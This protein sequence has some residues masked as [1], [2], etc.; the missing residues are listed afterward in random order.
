MAPM[1]TLHCKADTCPATAG[2]VA[3]LRLNHHFRPVAQFYCCRQEALLLF[4]VSHSAQRLVIDS[5]DIDCCHQEALSVL[6]L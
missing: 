2:Q 1:S 6:F 4:I 5:V 3:P